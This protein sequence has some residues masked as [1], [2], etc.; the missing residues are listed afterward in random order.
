MCLA[1]PMRL[2]EVRAGHTGIVDIGGVQR[3]VNLMLV[4]NPVPG[5]YLLVHAG[6]AIEKVDETEAE[7]RLEML[8]EMIALGEGRRDGSHTV[9]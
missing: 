3:V 6:F 8:R 4:E 9:S 7:E 5:D 2:E 1:V